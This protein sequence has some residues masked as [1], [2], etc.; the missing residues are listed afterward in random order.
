M[1]RLMCLL[2]S[3]LIAVDVS[4]G[5]V[6]PPDD[7][8]PQ[9]IT[10]EPLDQSNPDL[11]FSLGAELTPVAY[12]E[13]NPTP[14]P[15][16]GTVDDLQPFGR[17]RARRDCNDWNLEK[18][19]ESDGERKNHPVAPDAQRH[20]GHGNGNGNGNGG[21]GD[22]NGNGKHQD[23]GT[24]PVPGY[25][26]GNTND[27]PN[28]PFANDPLDECKGYFDVFEYVICDSGNPLTTS[29]PD[30]LEAPYHL[31][32]RQITFILLRCTQGMFHRV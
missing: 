20:T 30:I 15:C 24:T 29:P 1:C 14:D 19:A 25:G 9:S 6:E 18:P 11:G 12:N 3:I 32:L 8:E 2:I 4:I 23:S 28:F 13:L 21:N 5:I 10:S 31:L 7:G 26:G 22:R 17:F 16:I 27:P